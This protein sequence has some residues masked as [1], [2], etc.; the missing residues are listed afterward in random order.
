MYFFYILR[1]SDRSLY[2]GITTDLERREIEHNSNSSKAA[3]YTRSRSPV[4]LIYSESY[5]SL[6]DAMKREREVKSWKKSKKEDLV[7]SKDE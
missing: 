4:V 5:S 7:N 1:C 6:K 3:K 2:C